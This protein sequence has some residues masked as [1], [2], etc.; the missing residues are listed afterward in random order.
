MRTLQTGPEHS[1]DYRD[2]PALH[3]VGWW[4]GDAH[5]DCGLDAPIVIE[6]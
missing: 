4:T 3:L 1:C 6:R 5:G 2:R